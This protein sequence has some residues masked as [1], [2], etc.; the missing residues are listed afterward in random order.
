MSPRRPG[1]STIP[2]KK[3][4]PGRDVTEMS[5][6]PDSGSSPLT[7]E[8]QQSILNVIRNATPFEDVNSLKGTIQEVK[9]HLYNRDFITAFTKP[10]YRSAYVL[11]WSASRV[12]CYAEIF[13]NLDILS[14]A[15]TVQAAD[16]M[17]AQSASKLVCLGGGAGAE[18]VAL[19]A[20]HADSTRMEVTAVDI[21][22]WSDTIRA[23]QNALTTPP[24]LSTY[25][26]EAVRKANRAMVEPERLAVTFE[27]CDI[28]D[29]KDD[30]LRGMIADADWC[31]ICFTLNEL[32]N[33]SVSKTS[34]F[35]LK[36]GEM[37]KTGAR[38]LVIDS[39]GSYSEVKLGD[40]MKRYPMVWLL[41]H[42][43]K[44]VA[45]GK[46]EKIQ[47]DESRWFRMDGQ[48]TYPIDLEDMRYQIHVYKR[49]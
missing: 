9:T 5:Q 36:L 16:N 26:S 30:D 14:Q 33:S 10:D 11:R 32:F 31:T 17:Q 19:G 46:W 23:L 43:L 7:N 15:K 2:S 40:S 34:A 41:D 25:A 13:T 39:P 44:N 1:S 35:L 27:Q 42:T 12:L 8:L 49:M 3:K 21:A 47:E 20:L 48:V 38:L 6:E 22:D 37:M 24:P 4:A 28:L 45:K 29:C 18:I